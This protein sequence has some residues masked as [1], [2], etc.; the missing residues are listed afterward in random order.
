[1]T[2]TTRALAVQF[3]SL[4][5]YMDK[6]KA[7]LQKQLDGLQE[8]VTFW[9]EPHAELKSIMSC[10]P[11]ATVKLFDH[12][13]SI[14]ITMP[15]TGYLASIEPLLLDISKMLHRIGLRNDTRP[16]AAYTSSAYPHCNWYWSLG[17]ALHRY[18]ALCV[19]L[20]NG[21]VDCEV[22]EYR[23]SKEYLELKWKILPTSERLW[24]LIGEKMPEPTAPT[25]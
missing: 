4:A 13:I 21:A 2:A 7:E 20:P 5:D 16:P 8:V 1:M 22:S 3:P 14:T 19:E 18:I 9:R 24:E 17:D 6:R 15:E 10:W 11:D 12:S 25:A 23:E